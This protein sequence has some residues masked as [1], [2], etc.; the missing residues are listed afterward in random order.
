LL[1]SRAIRLFA[2]RDLRIYTQQPLPCDAAAPRDVR[3][4]QGA[5]WRRWL[6]SDSAKFRIPSR[7]AALDLEAFPMISPITIGDR[8]AR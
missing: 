6:T 8:T 5:A 3:A 7:A 2:C 1:A 4:A